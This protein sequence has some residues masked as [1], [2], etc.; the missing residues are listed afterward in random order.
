M[1]E[2]ENLSIQNMFD[3]INEKCETIYRHQTL[4]S[5]YSTIA[6]DY[7]SGHLLTEVE[8]HTLGYIEQHEGVTASDLA[9]LVFR[10]E[11]AVSQTISK[12]ESKGLITRMR[13]PERRKFYGI[14]LTVEGKKASQS[15][16]AYDRQ[17]QI[18][19]LN[20]LL[21]VCTIQEI[22]SFFK[23]MRCRIE[24]FENVYLADSK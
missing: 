4:L 6:R 18:D 10:T 9:K 16:L 21:K 12:L 7:G 23:V 24:L 19:T 22:E 20:E 1:K 15:H 8:A 13:I 2:N 5:N 3:S 11:S 17:H 14:Y